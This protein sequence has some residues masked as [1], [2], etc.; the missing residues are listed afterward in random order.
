MNPNHHIIETLT[1]IADS[2]RSQGVPYKYKAY[3]TAIDTIRSV[4]AP[5]T[6]VSQISS[7]PGIGKAMVEKIR[8]MLATGALQQEKDVLSDPITQ[9]IQ[10]FTSIHGIG[11]VLAKK[12]VHENALRTLDD[13]EASSHLLPPQARLGLKH[14]KDTAL[15]VPY[16]EIEDHLTYLKKAIGKLVDPKLQ[17]CV[18]GSHRRGGASSGD[19]DVLIT[20]PSS[21]SDSTSEYVYLNCIVSV[22]RDA[23]YIVDVLA[24]G[25][26]KFMGYSR[27][28]P[29]LPVRR[30]DMRWMPYDVFFPAL[31]YF[32][33]SDMFNITM[34]V[35]ALR[36]GYSLNEYG[37]YEVPG[38]EHLHHNPAKG[39]EG[40]PA[41]VAKG[42]KV[43]VDSE[44]AIFDLL[45]MMYLEPPQRSK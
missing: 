20:H 31:L 32:T 23:G 36:R 18:C 9:A 34:R 24:E 16:D 26:S 8:E 27:L 29:T 35:E 11:P 44:K 5:I 17:V 25:T 38:Y 6:D 28:H 45:G 33:G 2:Y 19:I 13:L 37:V 42:R 7:L 39:S 12:L 10:T 30:L 43:F 40:P 15:R 3:R 14:A 1:H 21:S 22:L 41:G 4:G